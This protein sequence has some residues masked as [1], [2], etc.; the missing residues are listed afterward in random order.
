MSKYLYILDPAHGSN[1]PGKRSP[2]GKHREYKWSRNMI[3]MILADPRSGQ[4]DMISPFLKH[5]LEPGLSNR[6]RTYND[7]NSHKPKIMISLHNNAQ[8]MGTDWM[9]AR[10]FSVYT[11]K[12]QTKSDLVAEILIDTFIKEFPQ[13][14]TRIETIDG[15]K[16]YEANFTVLMG[17]Y[18]AVLMEILFQDN[19]EDVVILNSPI[20]KQKFVDYFYDSLVLID[21]I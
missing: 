15:D 4:F 13:L 5:D 2:D 10:G 3:A 11:S 1:T 12:G 17:N 16:D 18:Y 21:K 20:F 7:I 6:V 19:I 14:K 9:K 8:G